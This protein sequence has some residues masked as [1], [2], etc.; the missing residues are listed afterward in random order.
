MVR[1]GDNPLRIGDKVSQ[2]GDNALQI[3]DK[4]LQTGDNGK[5]T[6]AMPLMPEENE[7]KS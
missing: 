3:G 1:I 2:I 7:L 4:L 5:L 6:I